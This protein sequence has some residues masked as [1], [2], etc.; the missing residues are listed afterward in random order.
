M[1]DTSETVTDSATSRYKIIALL[2]NG[3]IQILPV[4]PAYSPNYEYPHTFH[5]A[6]S[7]SPL[8][9]AYPL[10]RF[11][12]KR[13]IPEKPPYL[14]SYFV[15]YKDLDRN[16]GTPVQVSPVCWRPRPAASRFVA[17]ACLPGTPALS[18]TSPQARISPAAA[19]SRMRA[20]SKQVSEICVAHCPETISNNMVL[21]HFS[22]SNSRT[23][24]D[25]PRHIQGEYI[26]PKRHIYKHI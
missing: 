18:P 9:S 7:N 1:T 5:R 19:N 14:P 4:F 26:N 8:P 10:Y 16:F 6:T 15:N 24:K 13:G 25:H 17:S 23:L 20:Q 12:R 22:K 11:S 2:M 21:A 3:K